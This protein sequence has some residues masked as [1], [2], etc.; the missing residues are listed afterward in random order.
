MLVKKIYID[1]QYID[2][3]QSTNIFEMIL[4]LLYNYS[5][6]LNTRVLINM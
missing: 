5:E 3:L 2:T 1:S 4:L 6:Y